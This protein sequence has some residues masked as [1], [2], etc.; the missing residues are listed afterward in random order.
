MAAMTLPLASVFTSEERRVWIC[1]PPPLIT[2]PLIVEEA[3]VA[4]IEVVWIPPANVLVAVEVEVMFPTVSFPILDEEK[5]ES[6]KRPMFAKKEVEVAAV[7]VVPPFESMRKAVVVPVDGTAT[8][9][10]RLRLERDEVAEM[11]STDRGEEVP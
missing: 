4:L 11:E 3:L 8:I 2:S 1:T 6:T 7:M 5:K 10:K 9:W